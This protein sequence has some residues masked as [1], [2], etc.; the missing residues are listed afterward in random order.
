MR[1]ITTKLATLLTFVSFLT[2]QISAQNLPVELMIDMESF[3][4][5]N[6]EQIADRKPEVIKVRMTPNDKADRIYIE[7]RK[8]LVDATLNVTDLDGNAYLAY[9]FPVLSD[10]EMSIKSLPLGDYLITIRSDVGSASMKFNR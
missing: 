5:T 8:T 2:L 6:E 10:L 4:M 7:S 3:I 9:N 1:S